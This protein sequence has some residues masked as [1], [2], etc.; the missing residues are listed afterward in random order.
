MSV[1][2]EATTVRVQ[3]TPPGRLA[4]GW[5]TK[6]VAGEAGVTV[7]ATGVPLGHSSVKADAVTLTCLSKVTVTVPVSGTFVAPFAGVVLATVG[8]ASTVRVNVW[9]AS[10]AAALCAVM[11]IG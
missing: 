6:V 3:A 2:C 9:M 5:S 4:V 8:A 7:K 11:V 10:G 1:T